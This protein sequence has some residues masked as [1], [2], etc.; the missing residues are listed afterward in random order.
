LDVFEGRAFALPFTSSNRL[1]KP[2]YCYTQSSFTLTPDSLILP[3][4][5]PFLH[6]PT[7]QLIAIRFH[8]DSFAP[9]NTARKI[10]MFL[11]VANLRRYKSFADDTQTVPW[12]LWGPQSTRL[13]SE[14]LPKTWQRVIRGY[15]VVLPASATVL[16]FNEGLWGE[17]EEGVVEEASTMALD[18]ESGKGRVVSA[19]P[20]KECRL[21]YPSDC[22]TVMMGD[23][24]VCAAVS[25]F[26]FLFRGL[27]A[28][29][30]S[31]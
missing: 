23:E 2:H 22:R 7:P 21:V 15:R 11:L 8:H 10:D 27:V 12:E 31:L 18:A 20:Y 13:F 4:T 30:I 29:I 6:H 26:Y 14:V 25:E 5:Y 17:G 9:P 1:W 19:L 28:Y 3:G 24:I 16:D